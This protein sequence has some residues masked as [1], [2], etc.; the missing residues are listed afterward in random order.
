MTMQA[1]SATWWDVYSTCLL[2][3]PPKEKMDELQEFMSVVAGKFS[4]VKKDWDELQAERLQLME[5]NEQLKLAHQ[6]LG[7]QHRALQEKHLDLEQSCAE[8][9]EAK[10]KLQRESQEVISSHMKA[11]KERDAMWQ[12]M[13]AIQKEMAETV[14]A[15]Y[16]MT[17][18]GVRSKLNDFANRLEQIL[19]TGIAPPLSA[20]TDG[21]QDL[22]SE[23]LS[24]SSVET[25]SLDS[26][27]AP[28]RGSARK[29]KSRRSLRRASEPVVVAHDFTDQSG[30]I[31]TIAD[32]IWPNSTTPT[33]APDSLGLDEL[34]Q[35]RDG[36]KF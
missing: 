2:L 11:V 6:R 12:V 14:S 35:K 36:S 3:H 8:L 33:P 20:S 23:Q 10:T 15:Y 18:N 28:E 7:S 1:H 29:E 19:K 4:D 24:S 31:D 16:D 13:T 25:R 34:W 9:Q 17:P 32:T 26:G 27:V 22:T 21:L 5:E 30:H